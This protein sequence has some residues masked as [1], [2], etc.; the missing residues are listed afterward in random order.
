[1]YIAQASISEHNNTGWD[2]KSKAGD[3]T[4]KEVYI[5][6]WYPYNWDIILRY[7]DT[8]IA[9]RASDIAVKLANSNLIGYDQ[10]E[11]NTLY[12]ALKKNKWDVDKYIKSGVRTEC[13]CASFVYACY[14]CLIP[15]LRS[16]DNAPTCGKLRA[17]FK[18]AGFK[19]YTAKKYVT[20][21]NYLE[22]GD[23]I[24]NESAHTVIVV[25]MGSHYDK[26]T[27]KAKHSADYYD[28]AIARKY[29]TIDALNLRDGAGT[30]YKVLTVIP[31][32]TTVH[33]YGYYSYAGNTKWYYVKVAVNGVDYVGFVSSK[34]LRKV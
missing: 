1:M 31:A 11:R 2:G 23:V 25:N 28:K 13:D 6:S 7:P 8:T 15:A 30:N 3:Q 29:K 34:Y 4:G 26:K 24:V 27:V 16:D 21:D 20:S 10:S 12:K 22:A 18:K 9:R 5:R 17:M 14:C 19:C 32:K 33:N